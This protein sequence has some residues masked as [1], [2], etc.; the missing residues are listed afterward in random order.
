MFMEV[1]LFEFYAHCGKHYSYS[2]IS[3]VTYTLSAYH[4]HDGSWR[5]AL[6]TRTGQKHSSDLVCFSLTVSA[7]NCFQSKSDRLTSPHHS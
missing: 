4:T 3:A 1:I 2:G 6:K 5:H 7:K